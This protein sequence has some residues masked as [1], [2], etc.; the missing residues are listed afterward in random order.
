MLILL[1]ASEHRDVRSVQRELLA[2]PRDQRSRPKGRQKSVERFG[3]TEA[4]M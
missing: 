1:L 4:V 2:L 3:L